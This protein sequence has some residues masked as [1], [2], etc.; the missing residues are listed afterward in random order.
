ML[1]RER[2]RKKRLTSRLH[3]VAATGISNLQSAC[4]EL[5]PSRPL[6]QEA[7]FVRV[8]VEKGT[9]MLVRCR[10]LRTAAPQPDVT[11]ETDRKRPCRRD[12]SFD[13]VK[14]IDKVLHIPFQ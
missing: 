6:S 9:A 11:A 12:S 4:L 13:G 7:G 14:L 10:T 1:W 5:A 3:P 2:K 8:L